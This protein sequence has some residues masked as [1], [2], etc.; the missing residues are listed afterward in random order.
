MSNLETAT[1]YPGICLL[2]G[3][4]VSEGRG[5]KSPFLI[6]GAPWIDGKILA[7]SLNILKLPGVQFKAESFT[8]KSI[9]GMSMHPK[10]KDQKCEGVRIHPTDRS[11]FK[12][13]STGIYIVKTINSMYPNHFKWKINHFDRLCG[14]DLVR[15]SIN[16]HS[17]MGF[18]INRFAKQEKEFI[19]TQKS[20]LLYH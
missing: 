7:D 4:N 11:I 19:F 5:T 16:S 17:D 1:V 13:Y 2:E 9:P 18:L 3:T 12:S 15:K 6:F 20:Y 10:F 14:T 8:P